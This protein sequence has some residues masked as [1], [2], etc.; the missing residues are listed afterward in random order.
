MKAKYF[1]LVLHGHIPYV[2]SHGTWPHGADWLY[3]AAAEC[4][5]PLL[6]VFRRLSEE[7]VPAAVNFSFTP[8]LAD[9]LRDPRF[10]AGFDGYLDMK[11]DAAR[12]DIAF[13]GKTGSPLL[14]A[15]I[16]WL[17]VYEGLREDFNTRYQR[18]IITAYR[19][20][21]S[22]GAI[23]TMTS[24]ATHGYFPLLGR[25]Q[26]IRQQ[27]R[28]GRHTHKQLFGRDPLG[29]WLPECAYR[30]GYEWTSPFGGTPANRL[31]VDEILGSEGVGY[32]FVDGNLLKG[33]EAKGVYLDRFPALRKLRDRY[34]EKHGGPF[35]SGKDAF[36]PCL[37]EPSLVP[38]FVRDEVSGSQVWSRA[39]GY[40][41]DGNYLEFHKK[42]FPG[43]LR[44]WRITSS[45]S[46]LG[47]KLPYDQAAAEERVEAHAIHFVSV[48]EK[49]LAGRDRAGVVVSLYDAELFGHWWYEGP[50][51]IYQVSKKLA[52]SEVRAVTG[53]QCLRELP[54]A[55]VVSLPE[56]S[57]GQGGGHWVWLNGDTSWMWERIYAVEKA[58]AL[59]EAAPGVPDRRLLRQFFREKLLLESS[60]W[61]FLV[62]TGTARDYAELRAAGHFERASKLAEWL[63]VNRPLS[64]DEKARLETWEKE[65]NVFSE[66]IGTDGKVI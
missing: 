51:W 1:T 59:I 38:F 32:F 55:D 21:E 23:E 62:T 13:F 66:V 43:G 5:M 14:G 2:L 16:G 6:D 9:Q 25:D 42:H 15:A 20:L 40:P 64:A 28:Q 35:P 46:G 18:D 4:Y 52:A 19:E 47:D 54:P 44:Y 11:I 29:F 63:T 48:L 41:G 8:V 50:E 34:E 60:D 39:D 10:A 45:G 24:G 30:P 37:A 53:S 22:R 58:A 57:W 65:D 7:G 36:A 27:V 61:P 31:G 33:G 12:N 49:A 3:E 56:G 17:R 26:S